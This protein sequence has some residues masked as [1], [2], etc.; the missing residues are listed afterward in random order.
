MGF[1][2][3]KEGAESRDIWEGDCEDSGVERN[4]GWSSEITNGFITNRLARSTEQRELRL[5]AIGARAFL[6]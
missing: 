4:R 1:A 5:S 6:Q 2:N 3:R